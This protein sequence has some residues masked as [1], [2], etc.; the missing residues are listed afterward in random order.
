MAPVAQHKAD[1]KVN[2]RLVLVLAKGQWTPTAWADVRTGDL[3]KLKSGEFLPADVVLLSSSEPQG[4]AYIET[5]SLDGETNLKI[6]QALAETYEALAGVADSTESLKQA[7]KW[8][9]E[10]ELVRLCARVSL[11]LLCC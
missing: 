6:R 3:V 4:I 1:K 8:V 11:R 2:S 10:S 7:S 9:I 5:A